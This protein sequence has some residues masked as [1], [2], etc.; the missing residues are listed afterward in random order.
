[1]QCDM[2]GKDENLYQI[3]LEGSKLNV[4]KKCS[5]HGK[6][7]G[8]V[9][10]PPKFIKK[11]KVEEPETVYD[12]VDDYSAKIKKAREKTGLKQ[13]ELAAKIAEKSSLITK[14]EAGKF[15]PSIKVAKKIEKFLGLE[16]I[17]ELEGTSHAT[18][19]KTKGQ[20]FTIGDMIKIK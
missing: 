8:Q 10:E 12:I 4:C 7:I 16:L 20:G 3:E 9:K 11:P 18:T 1:M 13:E 17:Y 2:C 15:K 19:Q 6:F 14:I 5:K